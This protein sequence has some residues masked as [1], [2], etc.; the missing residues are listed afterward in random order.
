MTDFEI[1]SLE[2]AKQANYIQIIGIIFA[3]LSVVG[4]YIDYR[5]RKK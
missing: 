3:L 5:N 2:I 1:A 4:F